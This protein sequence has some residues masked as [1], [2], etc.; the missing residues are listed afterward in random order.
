[1]PKQDKTNR[2]IVVQVRQAAQVFMTIIQ[3]KPIAMAM[4]AEQSMKTVVLRTSSTASVRTFR[5]A[6]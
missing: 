6:M 4:R 2:M 3:M 5:D 1:M